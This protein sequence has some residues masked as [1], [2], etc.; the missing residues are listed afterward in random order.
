MKKL[1]QKLG[2]IFRQ[3]FNAAARTWRRLSDE[4]K[5]A[6]VI[7]STI[8]SIINDNF[9]KTPQF[10]LDLL[11]KAIPGATPEHIKELLLEGTKGLAIGS[12]LANLDLEGI[13]EKIMAFFKSLKSQKGSLWANISQTAASTMALFKAPEETKFT[14]ISSVI[15]YAYHTEVKKAPEDTENDEA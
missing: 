5:H 14:E 6:I 10:V 13:I 3:L 2:D 15:D 11:Q 9:D 12:E 4:L 7:G 1:I 8:I